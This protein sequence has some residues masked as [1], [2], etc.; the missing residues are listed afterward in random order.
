MKQK[1]DKPNLLSL[2]SSTMLSRNKQLISLN[3][4]DLL[5]RWLPRNN[6]SNGTSIWAVE[7]VAPLMKS[8]MKRQTV[9]C[10]GTCR[11]ISYKPV[12]WHPRRQNVTVY[13]H[14]W[15]FIMGPGS[16]QKRKQAEARLAY[17][18]S[19]VCRVTSA[20]AK[21]DTNCGTYNQRGA[22]IHYLDFTTFFSGRLSWL[23]ELQTLVLTIATET[24][25]W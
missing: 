2:L 3:V 6:T 25:A 19:T 12:W 1:I 7:G 10:Q 16:Q 5:R 18:K 17:A 14:Q 21:L 8:E 13:C 15:C 11:F 24:I 20:K 9:S 23:M 22:C 4:D